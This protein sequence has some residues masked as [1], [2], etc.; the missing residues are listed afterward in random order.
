MATE[1]QVDYIKSLLNGLVPENMQWW[2]VS[3]TKPERFRN[4]QRRAWLLQAMNID[5]RAESADG[6]NYDMAVE[7]YSKRLGELMATDWQAAEVGMASTAIGQ[8]KNC[9]LVW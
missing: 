4:F 1:K 8:L 7:M 6:I 9:K 5:S 3:E 2:A